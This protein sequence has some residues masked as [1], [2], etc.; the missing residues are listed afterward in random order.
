MNQITE[1]HLPGLLNNFKK[2][3]SNEISKIRLQVNYLRDEA[4]LKWK[5][6]EQMYNQM[7]K[8][9]PHINNLN[10][11]TN[12]VGGKDKIVKIEDISELQTNYFLLE[13]KIH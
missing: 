9:T 4:Q 11:F 2:Q 12:G 3:I 10:N 8:S 6:Y 7:I 1:K 13:S 5:K